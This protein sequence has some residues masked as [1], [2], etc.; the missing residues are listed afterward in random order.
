MEQRNDIPW[1]TAHLIHVKQG[2]ELISSMVLSVGNTPATATLPE[3]ST[4]GW[5]FTISA[6]S[7]LSLLYRNLLG[8]EQR[9][10]SMGKKK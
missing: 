6:S 7:I 9:K 5:V 1:I 2:C 3:G 10:Y 4:R 8:N